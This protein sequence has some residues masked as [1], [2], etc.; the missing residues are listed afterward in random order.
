VKVL[1]ADD[2]ADIRLLLRRVL[3]RNAYEVIEAADGKEALAVAREMQ[4]W[5]ALLDNDMPG[6]TG[7]ELATAFADDPDL[8]Q[9][10]VAITSV[11]IMADDSGARERRGVHAYLP[12][13]F[14]VVEVVTCIANLVQ[15]RETAEG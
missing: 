3:E 8:S 11:S 6:M 2:R 13:P 10:R 5:V 15:Q 14:S 1:V 4:P 7:L 9:I 12:K